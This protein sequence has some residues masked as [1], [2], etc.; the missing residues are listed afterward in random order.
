MAPTV[1]MPIRLFAHLRE[2]CDKR[3]TVAVEVPEGATPAQCL[4][5]LCALYPGVRRF[6]AGNLAVSINDDF[7]DWD[8]PLAEGDTVA[9]IPPISGGTTGFEAGPRPVQ[10]ASACARG[11]QGKGGTA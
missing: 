9:F 1:T 7:A 6:D 2:V 4:E 11:R 10:S 8:T 3:E 5:A